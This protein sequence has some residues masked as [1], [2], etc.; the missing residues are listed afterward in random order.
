MD[1]QQ[2]ADGLKTFK[3]LGV[4]SVTKQLAGLLC[5]CPLCYASTKGAEEKRRGLQCRKWE[6]YKGNRKQKLAVG[7]E[8]SQI[9]QSEAVGKA[10]NSSAG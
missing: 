3:G 8:D 7:K 5:T 2:L 9:Q 4:V 6:H 1:S 10:R